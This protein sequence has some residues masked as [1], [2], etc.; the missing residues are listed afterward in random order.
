MSINLGAVKHKS[1]AIAAAAAGSALTVTIPVDTSPVGEVEILSL[2][3]SLSG[4]VTTGT[5]SVTITKDA[6]AGAEYDCVIDESLAS[7][8]GTETDIVWQANSYIIGADGDKFVVSFTH[9]DALDGYMTV[10][11][12][13]R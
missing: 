9:T 12:L 10:D 13:V 11:F 3:L 4:A 7:K 5:D 1:A 6:V 8:W 2:T